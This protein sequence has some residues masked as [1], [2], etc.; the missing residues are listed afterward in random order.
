MKQYSVISF[1]RAASRR[2]Q[3]FF[4]LAPTPHDEKCTQAGEAPEQQI[5]ECTALINQLIRQ[6]GPAPEGA[7][8]F[9]VKNTGH[10][11]GTYYEAGIFYTEPNDMLEE[12]E[13][14]APCLL[15]AQNIENGIP[16]NWDDAAK[17]ELR[18]AGHP[19]Y[20]PAKVIQMKAA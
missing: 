1:D 2:S 16:D 8:F 12:D 20:Q 19:A 13:E 14:E 17:E 3:D 5:Q 4:T 18:E 10:D 15:Y 9:I 7:E 11:F 6:H